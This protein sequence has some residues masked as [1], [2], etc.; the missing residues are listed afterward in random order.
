MTNIVRTLEYQM[1]PA[2]VA[3]AAVL[4]LLSSQLVLGQGT[5]T[6]PRLTH[7][8]LPLYPPIAL[9]ARVSGK[10]EAD[11]AVKGGDVVTAEAKFGNPLLARLTTENI[12]TWHFSPEAYGTFSITFE[13]RIEGMDS[14]TPQNPRIEMRLPAFIRI[15]AAPIRPSC[16]DCEPGAEIV[17]KPNTDLVG[18]QTVRPAT[19]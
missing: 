2:F 8:D 14:P 12:K 17:G 4:M 18:Q 9:A 13:Y 3:F 19:D 7:A 15:T 6:Y 10:V 5:Q 11:F 1:K 16:N